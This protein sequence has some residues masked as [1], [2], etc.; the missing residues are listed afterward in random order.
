[1]NRDCVSSACRFGGVLVLVVVGG[2]AAGQEEKTLESA[3]GR[4][5]AL[6]REYNVASGSIRKAETDEKRSE[7][8]EGL[9]PFALRF[10]ELA[11]RHPADPDVFKILRSAIQASVS[12][13]SL[14]LTACELNRTSRPSA[15][16]D[17]AA[18]KI[19]A[20]LRRNHLRSDKIVPLCE[21]MRYSVRWEFAEFLETVVAES[22]HDE[23][24]AVATLALAQFLRARLHTRDLVDDRPE[25]IERYE[26]LFGRGYVR[27]LRKSSRPQLAA[28]VEAL[29]DKAA[30]FGDVELPHGGTVG[31]QAK[32]ALYVLRHLSIGRAAPEIEGDDQNGKKFR[33]SDY[34]GKVVLLYF[35]SEF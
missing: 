21:R 9:Q 18:R 35:W 33:L 29:F 20:F 7:A 5:D 14:S 30:A 15:S 27:T 19:A 32:A 4:F 24:R 31:E 17:E 22:P 23:V 25:L 10:L 2:V 3:K 8:A 6:R 11:E 13:D 26:S 1:M 34:R 12:A 16:R 28:R